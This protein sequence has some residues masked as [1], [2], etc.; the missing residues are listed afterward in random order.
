MVGDGAGEDFSSCRLRAADPVSSTSSHLLK[1]LAEKE[2]HLLSSLDAAI[3]GSSFVGSPLTLELASHRHEILLDPRRL[4]VGSSGGNFVHGG[5]LTSSVP[6][7]VF[8]DWGEA[9]H[10]F[11][12]V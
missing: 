4:N 10:A 7:E 2:L 6:F 12:V 3:G 8:W 11:S 5:V 1:G 9:I